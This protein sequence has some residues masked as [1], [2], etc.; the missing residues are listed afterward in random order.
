MYLYLS[1]DVESDREE[2][3]VQMHND[4]RY[5]GRMQYL[6]QFK[7][8][9]VGSTFYSINFEIPSFWIPYRK[10]PRKY[11]CAYNETL[12]KIRFEFCRKTFLV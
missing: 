5:H 2:F 12:K 6:M 10:F 4:G 9:R 3:E 1:S 11:V 8:L 7:E